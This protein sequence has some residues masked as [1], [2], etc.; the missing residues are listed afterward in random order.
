MHTWS[1][2]KIDHSTKELAELKQQKPTV[3]IDALIHAIEKRRQAMIDRLFRLRQHKLK[4]FFDEA[5]TMDN[6]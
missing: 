5:P 2:G 4:T 1:S 6:N 3:N